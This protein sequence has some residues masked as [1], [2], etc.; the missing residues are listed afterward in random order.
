[1]NSWQLKDNKM[2]KNFLKLKIQIVNGM[3][4]VLKEEDKRITD[5]YF[6]V[7]FFYIFLNKIY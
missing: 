2:S 3:K 6:I 7:K 1:M 4:R 5:Q